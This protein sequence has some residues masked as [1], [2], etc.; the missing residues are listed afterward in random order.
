MKGRPAIGPCWEWRRACSGCARV[1]QTDRAKKTF[2][3]TSEAFCYH[4]FLLK[5]GNWSAA[6]SKSGRSPLARSPHSGAS[7][8]NSTRLSWLRAAASS[9]QSDGDEIGDVRVA[10]PDHVQRIGP[11]GPIRCSSSSDC[12]PQTHASQPAR[13][14]C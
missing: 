1:G 7:K 8:P 11:T 14:A 4:P 2:S 12:V 5:L 3:T 9:A 6:G 13:K 10:L